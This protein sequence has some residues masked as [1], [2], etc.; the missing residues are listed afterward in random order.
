MRTPRWPICSAL[1]GLLIGCAVDSSGTRS[2]SDLG[3][4]DDPLPPDDPDCKS[5]IG[6]AVADHIERLALEGW[7]A[8][9]TER[10]L[11]MLGCAAGDEP[12]DCL[13]E[14]PLASD[15]DY[16]ATW[17]VRDTAI[18]VLHELTVTTRFWSRG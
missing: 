16:G 17:A 11:H 5:E 1:A 12:I 6:P 7:A 14:F 13:G 10:Q 4:A 8:V 9:N 2:G 18:R 15:T 3:K